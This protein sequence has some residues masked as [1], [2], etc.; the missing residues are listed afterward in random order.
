MF[1][2]CVGWGLG[3]VAALGFRWYLRRRL[4]WPWLAVFFTFFLA[5]GILAAGA[6]VSTI[7][8]YGR[9]GWAGPLVWYRRAIHLYAGFIFVSTS[10]IV[11]ASAR[12]L[13]D[14]TLTDG[15][16]WTGIAVWLM[17]ALVQLT[18]YACLR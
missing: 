8:A 15:L 6:I 14:W 5:A 9:S 17:I 4:S 11:L 10:A 13:R 1:H 2:Q 16:H 12:D 3:A 7:S 18:L